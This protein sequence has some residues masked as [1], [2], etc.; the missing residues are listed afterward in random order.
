MNIKVRADCL[1]VGDILPSTREAVVRG[2]QRGA[3]T[4]TGKVEI[5][6]AKSPGSARTANWGAST[7]IVVTRP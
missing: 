3:K 7:L 6:V 5:V 1:K 2:P 4:P